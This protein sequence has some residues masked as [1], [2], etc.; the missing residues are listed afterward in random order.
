MTKTLPREVCLYFGS[1][2]P[3]HRAHQSLIRYALESLP[4]QEVWLVLSPVNPLKSPS[5]QLPFAWRADYIRT[6]I[7]DDPRVKLVTLEDILPS[8][9][10]TVHTLR[11]LRLLHPDCHFSLFIG[12]DNLQLLDRWYDYERL[13]ATTPLH[14]YPRP[15]YDIHPEDL[16]RLGG[17][18]HLHPEA[19]EMLLSATELREAALSSLDRR[20]ETAVPSLW[21]ELR[22]QLIQLDLRNKN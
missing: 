1:F 6:A 10:Y 22:A 14:V 12:S 11:A 18:I 7:A 13:L 3:L 2:N 9:H 21:E 19:P 8:P 20:A 17:E 4:C 16:S 5:S 15:G